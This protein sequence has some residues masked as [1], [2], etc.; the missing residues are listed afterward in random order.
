MAL[1]GSWSPIDD[2]RQG[3]VL[4]PLGAE[5]QAVAGGLDT[6]E[7]DAAIDGRASWRSGQRRR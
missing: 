2:V 3:D 5:L 7:W 6:A 1:Q 4:E